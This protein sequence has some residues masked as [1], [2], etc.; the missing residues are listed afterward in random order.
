MA[1]E[2]IAKRGQPKGTR[3]AP[4]ELATISLKVP[5]EMKAQLQ[6]DAWRHG[7]TLSELIRQRVE[8]PR[9]EGDP[10][11][12]RYGTAASGETAYEGDIGTRDRLEGYT[13]QL[14]GM[15]EALL[16]EG[17]Q[18]LEAWQTLAIQCLAGIAPS[19][20]DTPA[21]IG[22]REDIPPYD[23]AT[24]VL[25]KLCKRGHE[26]GH[27]GQSLL[28]KRNKGCLKCEAEKKREKAKR[29]KQP[30]SG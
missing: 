28:S 21:L 13:E 15:V 20:G 10:L 9:G 12:I 14:G 6:D 26:W 23:S 7:L 22:P 27:T 17:R 8:R 29:K 19:A 16:T 25:G 30:V 24:Q 11:N 5:L 18:T 1:E 2:T 3:T 4:V